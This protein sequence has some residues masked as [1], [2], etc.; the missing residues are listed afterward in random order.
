MIGAMKRTPEEA[1]RTREA[2]CAAALRTFAARGYA[3]TT[4][5]EVSEVAGL[6]RGAIYHHFSNKSDLYS[7]C[8]AYYWARVSADVWAALDTEASALEGIRQLVAAFCRSLV[9]DET[10]LLLMLTISARD[11]PADLGMAGKQD[12]LHGLASRI[13][14][15]SAAAA[16]A[17]DLRPGLTPQLAAEY[18][19]VVLAGMVSILPLEPWSLGFPKQAEAVSDVVLNG[20]ARPAGGCSA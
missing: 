6:T 9:D 13:E 2:L 19:M 12:A 18:V 15:L 10:R 1:A 17:G 7:G 3:A 4:L 20:I 8:I 14:E 11:V 16:E 5:A